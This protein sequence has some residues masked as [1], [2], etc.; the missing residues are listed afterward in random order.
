[1]RVLLV[2]PCPDALQFGL[3]PFFQTE[4]LGLEYIASA[5][6]DRGHAVIVVDMRFLNRQVTYLL[7]RYR[8]ELVGIACLHILDAPATLR[9]ANEVKTYSKDI[10]VIAGGHAASAYP[11]A[12]S[13]SESLDAIGIGEGEALMP[14]LCDAIVKRRP[15]EEVPSLLLRTGSTGFLRTPEVEDLPDFAHVKPPDRAKIVSYQKHY[16]CLNYMPVWTLETTRGCPHRCK[17][18][19]VWQFYRGS[20]RFHAPASVRADFEST[21]RNLFVIDDIFWADKAQSEEL[22]RTLLNSGMRKSWMLVQTRADL[23]AGHP[24]L[25]E[26][27]RP[28]S[29]RFDIFFGFEAPTES[30]LNSLNKGSNVSDTIEAIN[31]ARSLGY[32]VTGNFIIDPDFTEDDFAGLWDF[33]DTHQ[34]ARVGF[35]ILTPLPGTRYFE[36]VR[37]QLS[38]LDWNHYDLH[39]LLWTPRLPVRRFFELYCET[40]RR[41]VLNL[42]GKKKWWSWLGEVRPSQIPRLARILWRTQ[43]LMDPQA[44]LDET[45]V[46]RS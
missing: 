39:H 5:L 12:L 33:L 2:K 28:L 14:A 19:S 15:L 41:S 8:P 34:L 25:L 7:K 13:H 11:S 21:G 23:V 22:A 4:P 27:W 9:L 18:C 36:Q 6:A 31:V 37:D 10:F 16:C 38:V 3:A 42:A 24:E 20:C 1:M 29:D 40:W 26:L 30:R 32:G 45:K 43:K 46:S 35:T 44:Y 17:F